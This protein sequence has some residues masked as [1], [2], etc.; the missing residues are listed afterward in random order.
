[1]RLGLMDRPWMLEIRCGIS[2][3]LAMSFGNRAMAQDQNMS[4]QP[5]HKIRHREPE[6]GPKSL[7]KTGGKL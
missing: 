7:R 1:M 4:R 3:D 6:A 2:E 5:E